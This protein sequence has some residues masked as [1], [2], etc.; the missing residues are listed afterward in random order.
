MSRTFKRLLLALAA[1]AGF[2]AAAMLVATLAQIADAADRI[3]AGA[4]QTVFW[5]LLVV[6][7][8]LVVA[9]LLMIARLPKA[10]VPP[11]SGDAAAAAAYLAQLRADLRRN[12][13][14]AGASFETDADVAAALDRLGEEADRTALAAAS[15]VFVSTA[16]MQ[17]GRLDGLVVLATQV[18]LVWRILSIYNTRTTPSQL[19][20]VYGNVGAAVLVAGAVE[21]IDFAELASPIVTAVAPAFVAGVPGLGGVARLLG[22]SLASGG[23][24]A[25]L[26]LR[27]AMLTREY[28]RSPVRPEEAQVRRSASAAAL[29]LLATVTSRCG[30]QVVKAVLGG[31]GAAT[32][33]AASAAAETVRAV[34][35]KVGGATKATAQGVSQGARQMTQ[36]VMTFGRGGDRAPGDPPPDAG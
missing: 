11:S 36:R 21:D 33:G 19:A 7:V 20:Y 22:N 24:N 34:G 8:G 28:C 31:A 1:L 6:L 29:V 13:L 12:P 4:G 25:F 30:T 5:S 35:A 23:A 10:R 3:H 27:V 16:L 26:T 32:A 18:R 2:A 17:N 15:A 14:L 9:P